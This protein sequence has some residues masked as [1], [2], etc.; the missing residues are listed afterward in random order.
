MELDHD[1]DRYNEM[2][3]EPIFKENVYPDILKGLNSIHY[4][5]IAKYL[6][7]RYDSVMVSKKIKSNMIY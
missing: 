5:K 6:R 3:K 7:M 1:E 4:Q 2:I